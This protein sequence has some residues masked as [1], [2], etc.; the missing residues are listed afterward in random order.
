MKRIRK[1]HSE[2]TKEKMRK[3]ALSVIHIK[4]WILPEEEI[5]KKLFDT[6]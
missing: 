4:K 1:P 5:V 3:S 6:E 2:T